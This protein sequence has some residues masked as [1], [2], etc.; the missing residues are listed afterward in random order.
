MKFKNIICIAVALSF[1]FALCSC[2]YQPTPPSNETT[3]TTKVVSSSDFKVTNTVDIKVKGKGDIIVDLYG[4]EAPITVQNFINLVNEKFYDG[5][6]FHRIMSGFMIQGG[7]PKGD[8]TGGATNNIKGEFSI[9]GVENRI[10]HERGVIS[11][12]R[13]AYDYD[14]ASSQFFIMHVDYIGLDGQY[15]A[16]GKVRSGME[17]VDDLAENTPVIDDNGTVKEGCK[18]IIE[19]I[20]EVK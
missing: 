17:I 3:A 13:T 16:F 4:E 5:L 15:A 19:S 8:G 20:R 2:G 10:S 6:T 12:G 14:S 9:N 1:V 7:D 11:M 18:P